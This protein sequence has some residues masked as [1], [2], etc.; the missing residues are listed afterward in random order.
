MF[1]I[2]FS[3]KASPQAGSAVLVSQLEGEDE[4]ANDSSAT[5]YEN[6]SAYAERFKGLNFFSLERKERRSANTKWRS[7]SLNYKNPEPRKES[8]GFLLPECPCFRVSSSPRPSQ[9]YFLLTSSF[10]S[11][12]R[13]SLLPVSYYE[14]RKPYNG[15]K[16]TMCPVCNIT[17]EI[18]YL[19][20][21]LVVCALRTLSFRLFRTRKSE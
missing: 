7:G 21:L 20:T 6:N 8:T 16:M 19:S 12:P 11:L 9:P 4:I 17:Q 15:L 10:L 1:L 3:D 5:H 18:I 2:Y 14:L 13:T